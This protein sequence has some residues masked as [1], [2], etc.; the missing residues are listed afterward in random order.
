M[1]KYVTT[2]SSFDEARKAEELLKTSGLP[3]KI[4]SPGP[5]F[6]RVGAPAVVLS[7]E[8]RSVFMQHGG[9]RIINSGWVEYREAKIKIPGSTP[10]IFAEDVYGKSSIVVL[11]P[12]MADP[13]KIRTIAY[14]TGNLTEVFP[15][16][17]AEMRGAAYNPHAHIFT[18]MDGYRMI[19][20]YAQRI[21][22]AKADEIV[23]AW[24]VLEMVR[25]R[26]NT[27]WQNRSKI[28]PNF[29]TRKKPPA[30][31]IYYRLPK[32][33][34]KQC[35]EKTCMAF[36]LQLW[37]GKTVPDR[38]REVFAG[39]SGHLKEALIE[40]CRG[41]GLDETSGANHD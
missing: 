5:G 13:T 4:L 3:Y 8:T 12:C 30:L 10:G 39:S 34:C 41:L 18:F 32:T 1:S 28:T 17:N 23:D 14:I 38:C 33:N 40:I 6:E 24:R 26:A 37:S 2:F 31:E 29:E 35:G 21:A 11:A 19:C 20:L 36:A 25:L 16:M 27:C 7:R 9:D 15:Y 22:I